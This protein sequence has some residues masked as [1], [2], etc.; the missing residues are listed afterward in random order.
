MGLFKIAFLNLF[1]RKTRTLLALLGIALGVAA[2]IVLVSLVD[3]VS[4]QFTDALAQFQGITVMEKDTLDQSLSHL[5]AG[6]EDKLERVQGVKAAVREIWTVPT[7]IDGKVPSIGERFTS[8]VIVYGVDVAKLQ[9]SGSMGWV[10]ELEKGSFLQAG[11]EGYAVIGKTLADDL[12]KF[13]GSSLKVNDTQFR[14][15]GILKTESEFTGSLIVLS[16]TDAR[17]LSGFPSGQVSSFFVALRNPE[18]DRKVA[19][20]I[21][22]RF[23]DEVDARTSSDYSEQFGGV[24]DSFRLAV[25]LV[26]GISAV[27]AGVGIMNTVLMG[28]KER[29]RELGTL[30]ATGWTSGIVLRMVALESV[31]LG[32]FGG[33]I[34]VGL[35]FL[36]DWVLET[37]FALQSVIGLPL[38]AE[39]LGFAVM[40]GVAASIY[41][42]WVAVHLDPVEAI[43]GG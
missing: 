25:F 22:F 37:Q 40:V 12:D 28:V 7:K 9:Q 4:A 36:V 24:L 31:F 26:A 1:R 43:R 20:F 5:D 8:T 29:Y 2:M 23:P 34:G 41:P 42:S 27:V 10:G 14:I 11:Q 6:L 21:G 18:E 35:A 13:V 30:K 33:L 39:A 32:L 17:K 38:L 3:G 19:Q 15:R 16:E